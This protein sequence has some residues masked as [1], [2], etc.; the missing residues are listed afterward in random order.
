MVFAVFKLNET[1]TR[2][3]YLHRETCDNEVYVIIE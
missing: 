1:T 2:I 3:Y